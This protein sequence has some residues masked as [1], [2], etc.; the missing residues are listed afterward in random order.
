MFVSPYRKFEPGEIIELS[1]RRGVDLSG[2]PGARGARL[3]RA[4]FALAQLFDGQRD[5]GAVADAA[6]EA[7]GES[8]TPHA[9]ERFA[10]ELSLVGLL[11]AGSRE[12]LPVPAHSDAEA[13]LL[14]RSVTDPT[15]PTLSGM[16]TP[17]SILPGS[18]TG[19]GLT[20]S[21]TGLVTGR[22]GQANHIS[23]LLPPQLLSA[24]GHVLLWP[25]AHRIL[26]LLFLALMTTA[27]TVA[28]THRL[29]WMAHLARAYGGARLLSGAVLGGY[30]LNLFATGARVAA[31]ARYTAERPRVGIVFG[32]GPLHIPRLFVDTAGASERASRETRLR[33]VGA[34]LVGMG[35][36]FVAAVLVWFLVA[37]THPVVARHA[38]VVALVALVFGLFRLN[39]LA[40]YDG[41]FL[42]C[43][44]LG[45]M[46]LRTEAMAVLFGMRRPWQGQARVISRRAMVWYAGA[47][48]VFLIAVLVFI[49]MFPLTSLIERLNGLGFLLALAVFGVFMQKQYVRSVAMRSSMGWPAKG[50][51]RW[52]PSLYWTIALAVFAVV[53]M[54]PYPYEPSGDFE[55]LPR[56]RADVRA[57]T[58]GDVLEVLK[59]ENDVVEKDT[60]IVKLNDAAQVAKVAAAE[61]ELARNKAELGLVRLGARK[62]EIE[63]ARQTV[64]TARTAARI[65]DAEA[66][67][68]TQA[69]KGK[70]VTPQEY[71]R[72]RGAADV[73]RQKLSEAESGLSL[74]SSAARNESIAALEAEIH[75]VEVQLVYL[76]Q[77]LTYTVI[78]APIAGRIVSSRLQFARGNYLERGE[79]LA[80]IEDTGE[81]LAE[82][83]M[84]ESVMGGIALNAQ[85]SAKPWA[86]PDA[87]F[88]GTVKSIAPAAERAEYGKIVRVQMVVADPDNKLRTGMTGSAKVEAGTTLVIVAFTKALV[89][90][91]LVEVWSWIP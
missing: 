27:L 29:E 43:N 70:S 66:A 11:R 85:A 77:E 25:L 83:R 89:R 49:A 18:R 12:P 28:I 48:I 6:R 24:F 75:K 45:K 72:A 17:P 23:W 31:I 62:E 20:G 1:L 54:L 38:V 88:K 60:P 82:I 78:K 73:A 61:A 47:V 33:I 71:D 26:L 30:L 51:K 5:A 7:F 37:E 74:V 55:V 34:A 68:I 16:A 67:R 9:V 81:L 65:A 41:Y 86:Y 19:P 22:R 76:R 2:A 44:A 91:F 4:D 15:R 35:A 39:P 52:L 63:V 79:L 36:L 8:A 59:H 42:L 64:A 87:S 80:T 14:G 32:F 3:S 13:D 50:W 84:P 40:P 53:C 58:A 56:N 46:D 90:F 57:L 21:L 10:A 69:Y